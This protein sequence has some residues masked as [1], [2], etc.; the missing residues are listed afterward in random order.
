[1]KSIIF[2]SLLLLSKSIFGNENNSNKYFNQ[3]PFF[4]QIPYTYD[5]T[6]NVSNIGVDMA[7]TTVFL[8]T[9]L[10]YKYGFYNNKNRNSISAF[11]GVGF[12]SFL[13]IQVGYSSYKYA[14]LRFRSDWRFK[15]LFGEKYYKNKF[16][17]KIPHASF[18]INID[19]TL[20]TTKAGWFFSIGLGY[21]W[22][23]W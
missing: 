2:L 19:N 7:Y 4:I 11:A 17:E 18:K 13:Q 9:G 5:L 20:N 3:I 10:D 12:L 23:G 8:N 6:N 22:N 14:I 21:S 15:D 1:M 16:F